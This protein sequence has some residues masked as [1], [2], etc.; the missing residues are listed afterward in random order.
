MTIPVHLVVI[1]LE[2]Y[3]CYFILFYTRRERALFYGSNLLR[4]KIEINTYFLIEYDADGREKKRDD[5]NAES[6]IRRFTTQYIAYYER[7]M[8]ANDRGKC[9]ANCRISQFLTL[10]TAGTSTTSSNL[11][12]ERLPRC[13]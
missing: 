8:E 4:I 11:K 12:P 7:L 1:S 5:L 13:N 10:N 9:Q 2:I 6:V 3:P